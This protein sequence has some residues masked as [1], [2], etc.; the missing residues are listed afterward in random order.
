MRPVGIKTEIAKTFRQD[1]VFMIPDTSRV[2]FFAL[3]AGAFANQRYQL[4]FDQGALIEVTSDTKSELVGFSTL[5]IKL[6]TA[7]ISAPG[8]A[9]GLR[10]AALKSQDDYLTAVETHS[11]KVKISREACLQEPESCPDTALKILKIDAS[12]LRKKVDSGDRGAEDSVPN[13]GAPSTGTE[14]NAP[15]STGGQ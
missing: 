11:A 1:D 4:K 8:T 12:P 2:A 15:V 3:P 5:P 7:I 6:I 13:I 9:L 10:S 14:G